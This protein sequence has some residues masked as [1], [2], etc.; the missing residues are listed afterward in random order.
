M[1]LRILLCATVAFLLPK[2]AQA[3]TTGLSSGEYA[4]D[5]NALTIRLVFAGAEVG[6]VLGEL[7]RD[8][9]GFISPVE[10]DAG[11]DRLRTKIAQK[12]VV[13]AT[14]SRCGIS[15]TD[16][17]I[18]ENDGL[19]MVVRSECDA[20]PTYAELG[21][22]S[23]FPQTHKHVARILNP[24]PHDELL[25]A[26]R[27]SISLAPSADT[28]S[29]GEI[30]FVRLGI[31]HILSGADHLLF[32]VALILGTRS[33]RELILPITAFTVA[34]SVSLALAVFGIVHVNGRVVEP[35]IAF[36]IA[37]MA[38]RS[39]SSTASG[40]ELTTFAFG[41]IHGLGFAGA[42]LEIQIPRTRL[43]MALLCFNGGV[44]L[45]QLVVVIIAL[46]SLMLLIRK[47]PPSW[48]ITRV[49]MFALIA[50]G[51]GWGALRIVKG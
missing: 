6:K 5:G 45:G 8:R 41:L 12:I 50:I 49:F 20:P 35:V 13:R 11:R 7:D 33:F 46:P 2:A 4:V 44:E 18:L 29:A 21:F 37:W 42:M 32:L 38:Y 1:L 40:R 39:T 23:D 28:V 14:G 25:G 43:P 15:L 36:S 19:L 51:M 31:I 47:T 30:D 3:H 10:V 22:L 16:A 9:D 27:M 34:H 17:A 24:D 26:A 48:N